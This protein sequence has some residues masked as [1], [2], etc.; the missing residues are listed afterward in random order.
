MAQ[1]RILDFFG[2]P[3]SE[4]STTEVQRIQESIPTPTSSSS[5]PSRPASFASETANTCG[6]NPH[7]PA[8]PPCNAASTG[9]GFSTLAA[10]EEPFQ[11]SN[12]VFPN[13]HFGTETFNR[14]FTP[15]WFNKWKWLHYV[16]ETNRVLC[17]ACLKAI[18][19]KLINADSFR[20]DNPFV[21]GGFGNWRKATAKFKEHERSKLHM[22]SV[23][24]HVA[25]SNAPINALLSDALA[26]QQRTARHVLELLF[27][28]IRFLGSK[29]M[30]FRGDTTRDGILYELMLER[31]YDLPKEREWVMRRDNWMSNTIQSEIIQQFAHAIQR[32]IVARSSE[33]RFYGLTA[34]GT[35]DVSTTEQFSCNLQFVDGSLESHCLFLGFYNAQDSTGQTL[36]SCIKDVF[37]RLNIPIERLVAYCFDGA[38]NMSG[39]FSGVQAR[40]KELCP[41][42]MYVHCNNH[43]LDLVLQEVACEV[44]LVADTLNFVRGVAT[45]IGESPKRKQL[46]ESLFGCDEVAVNILGLCP[47]RWCVRATAIKRVCFSYALFE[48]CEAVARGLQSSKAS[49]LGAL[50]CANVLKDRIA[51]LRDDDIVEEMVHKVEACASEMDLK[52]PDTTARVSR[53]PGRFRQTTEPEAVAHNAATVIWRHQFYQAVDLVSAELKRRFDQ[54]SMTLA[55]S[56]ER[57][58]IVAAGGGTVDLEPLQLPK[59][60][61]TDRLNLQLKMLCDVTRESQC[62]THQCRHRGLFRSYPCRDPS[63][64]YAA[65]KNKAHWTG[66]TA[67]KRGRRGGV[68]QRLRRQ[69]YRRIPL[70]TVILA[71]VQ[72]LRNK[73]DE[74]QANVKFLTEYSSACLLA[75]TETWLKEHDLQS[76]LEI[77]GF[78][79][80]YRL[81]RDPAVT[82]VMTPNTVL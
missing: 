13:R 17:F 16:T 32:D 22:D 58:V 62:S 3:A 81:D 12:F 8:A 39:C 76:D 11:P 48:P 14:T 21:S 2:T 67:R 56:R 71:N 55:A 77:D 33:S 18:E 26:E 57:A 45:V 51:A 44:S 38:S 47:T 64:P 31:T 24:R 78:G 46:F 36:F 82:V 59:E 35:T 1:K 53:T 49:A 28:S 68:R 79:V 72:S 27:R 52:M 10:F 70:P 63:D 6:N 60:L 23:Q 61:D 69:G 9:G 4:K 50:E 20:V 7:E 65:N 41:Q 25:L 74:L 75:F 80:P 30:P 40:L 66:P 73:V 54:E 42:S 37:L 15:A 5:E 29:G 19:K 43:A 34:D